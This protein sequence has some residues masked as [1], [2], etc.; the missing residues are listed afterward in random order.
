[1]LKAELQRRSA[2][3]DESETE[4]EKRERESLDEAVRAEE[5]R[6]AAVPP[7]TKDQKLLELYDRRGMGPDERT[8]RQRRMLTGPRASVRNAHLTCV[9]AFARIVLQD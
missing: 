4:D 7:I 6:N 9:G 5:R 2:K 8:C 3:L 1:L